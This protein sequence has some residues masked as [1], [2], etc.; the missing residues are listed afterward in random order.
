MGSHPADNFVHQRISLYQNDTLGSPKGAQSQKAGD[1]Y[2]EIPET[3]TPGRLQAHT[4]A[5]EP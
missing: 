3:H 2:T 4:I 1:S 5:I